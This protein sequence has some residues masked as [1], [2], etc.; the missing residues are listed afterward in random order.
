MPLRD[1]PLVT[2][3][4]GAAGFWVNL[5]LMIDLPLQCEH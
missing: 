1:T 4:V 3:F 5:S 2:V